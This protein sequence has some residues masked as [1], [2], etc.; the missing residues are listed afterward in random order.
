MKHH[1]GDDVIIDFKGVDV[2]GEVIRQS[3]GW[4]MAVVDIDGTEDFGSVGPRLDP[5]STICV[6]EGRVKPAHN[7]A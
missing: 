1:P 5:R 4:V 6:P 2:A 7:N 3:N